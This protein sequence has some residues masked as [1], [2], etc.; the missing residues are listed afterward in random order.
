M[1]TNSTEIG[2]INNAAPSTPAGSGFASL[3]G[4]FFF[5]CAFT[6][7]IPGA[8]GEGTATVATL[9]G[10]AGVSGSAD[11]T[12]TAATFNQPV[13]IAVDRSGNVYVADVINNGVRK[14][15]SKGVVKTLTGFMFPGYDNGMRTA[16]SY[17]VPHGIAVDYSGNIYVA[18]NGAILL[19]TMSLGGEVTTLAGG[20]GVV[21]FRNAIGT[22]ASFNKPSG[23]AV[24]AS[25][26][27]YVADTDNNVIRE[28]TPD[29]EVTTLAGSGSG[30]SKNGTGSE[31]SFSGP[32]GI[33]VDASGNVYVA[34]KYNA[35]IRKITP[36][37]VV[38]T[39]AGSG[40]VGYGDGAGDTATFNSPEGIAVD[41]KGNVYVADTANSL[42]RKI[43][44]NGTVETL[45][46]KG[47]VTGSADGANTDATFNLPKAIAVDASGKVFVADT[48]NN[49]IRVITQ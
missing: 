43:A 2:R 38:T 45:A 49:T 48:G 42:I 12:G 4:F 5:L 31:A 28:V 18:D 34:D 37:G 13:G 36:E 1:R 25:G 30:G 40:F 39:L 14:I 24:D 20:A 10:T 9:A 22:S 7:F 35:M 21:G 11:G 26:N 19:R 46:G 16:D 44:P 41:A 15:N 3:L 47:K 8:F 29:G 32:T 17:I 33:A 23:V 6:W 27:V